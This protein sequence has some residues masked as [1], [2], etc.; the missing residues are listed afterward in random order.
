MARKGKARNFVG[1]CHCMKL[2]MNLIIMSAVLMQPLPLFANRPPASDFK[3]VKQAENIF[4]Y[5]RWIDAPD[6]G[7]VREIKAIFL[8]RTDVASIIRLLKDPARGKEWN[9]NAKDYRVMPLPE[10]NR[11]ISYIQYDIPWP[12]DDQDCCLAFHYQ[13]NEVTFQSTQHAAFPVTENMSRI[14]GTRGRWVLENMHSGNVKVTYFITTD[15]SKKIPRW[16]SDPIVHSNL[17]KTMAQFKKLAE[18]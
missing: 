7:K 13:H 1:K 15:R 12:F 17:F 18:K 2:L 5:E 3:L 14:T 8:V 6:N 9:A 11:W 10:E 16:V 4:L